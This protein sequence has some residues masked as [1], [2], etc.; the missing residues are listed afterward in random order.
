MTG[1]LHVGPLKPFSQ[2]QPWSELHVP[3]PLQV[4]RVQ[5]PVLSEL[6][7]SPNQDSSHVQFPLAAQVPWPEQA[8]GH[9]VLLKLALKPFATSGFSSV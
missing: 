4:E 8:A 9:A 2:S 3:W 7:S 1:V 5:P 6:Q